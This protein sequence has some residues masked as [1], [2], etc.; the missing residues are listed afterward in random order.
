MEDV[1]MRIQYTKTN[2][3]AK[4]KRILSPVAVRWEANPLWELAKLKGKELGI[5]TSEA[6]RLIQLQDELSKIPM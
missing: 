4:R 6:V 1:P 5:K 3:M 2:K